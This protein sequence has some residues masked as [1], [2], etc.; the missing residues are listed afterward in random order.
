MLDCKELV[1]NIHNKKVKMVLAITGGGTEAIGELL[2]HGK[3]SNTVLTAIIPYSSK[4]LEDFVMR[5]VAKHCSLE[6]AKLM[7]ES[8]YED[9]LDESSEEEA[10]GVGVTC[11]LVKENERE[12]R[13]HHFYFAIKG[14]NSDAEAHIPVEGN[15]REEQ[16][17]FVAFQIIDNLQAFCEDYPNRE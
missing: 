12:G 2:R 17:A 14:T 9:A 13:E 10:I 16:E 1:E 5:K 6:A 15:T 8:A 7:A 3:A 4:G 11:S